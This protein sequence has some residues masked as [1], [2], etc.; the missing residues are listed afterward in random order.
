MGKGDKKTK[1]GKIIMGSYGVRRPRKSRSA[2]NVVKSVKAEKPE[3]PVK[4]TK[5]KAPA[6]S[7][8]VKEETTIVVDI[9]VVVEESLVKTEP[10][11]VLV[12][13]TPAA[14]EPMAPVIEET[15]APVVEE[16]AKSTKKKA[17]A[18]PK[19]TKEEKPKTKPKDKA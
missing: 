3:K 12:V 6:K 11:P 10:A 16:T 14:E 9:P 17:P 15:A 2:E 13:E 8:A 19:A 5:G 7:K 18:K 1:R 4:A